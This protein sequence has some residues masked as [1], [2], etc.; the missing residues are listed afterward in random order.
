[1]NI[2]FTPSELLAEW[3]SRRG[4]QPLRS[5]AETDIS[6]GTDITEHCRRELSDWLAHTYATAPP[7][8]LET[9]ELSAENLT[10]TQ[11]FIE[12]SAEAILPASVG[13]VTEVT[14]NGWSRPAI[15]A[16]TDT[17]MAFLEA[18]PFLRPGSNTPLAIMAGRRLTVMPASP[19][20]SASISYVPVITLSDKVIILSPTLLATMADWP[21]MTL[22][23]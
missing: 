13:R 6:T 10:W 19:R 5:D 12:G 23:I 11:G 2:A 3:L 4:Y 22:P 21:Q 16:D 18:N 15:P 20:L 8:M 9:R 7:A 14:V 17:A 1:M